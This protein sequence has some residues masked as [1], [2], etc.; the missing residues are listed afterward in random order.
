M[1]IMVKEATIEAVAY[2]EVM[3]TIGGGSRNIDILLSP[4]AKFE[5]ITVKREVR[6]VEYVSKKEKEIQIS[7]LHRHHRT[8]RTR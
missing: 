2:P 1:T 7:R 4:I 5:A 6:K 3:S 8:H